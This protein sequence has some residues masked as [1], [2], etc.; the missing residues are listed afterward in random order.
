MKRLHVHIA[1]NDLQQNVDFYSNL[2]N[3][4]PSLHKEDYAKWMLDDPRVNFSISNR[5]K[6]TGL[7]HLGIQAENEDELSQLKQ[8]IE[9]ADAPIK[10]EEG[11][12]CCYTRSDKHWTLDPQGVAWETFHS[13][14]EI[15]TFNEAEKKDENQSGACCAPGIETEEKSSCC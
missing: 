1:V 4:Q 9:K 3:S 14:Q 8:N 15:P 5:S 6:K 13:L 7:D 12:A 10:T 2:F 11:T